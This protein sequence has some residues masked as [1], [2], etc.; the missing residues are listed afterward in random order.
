MASR[1]EFLIRRISIQADEAARQWNKTKDPS[2]KD[3]WYK[4]LKQVPEPEDLEN[5]RRFSRKKY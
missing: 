5:E 2:F 1:T 3:Q 4:L